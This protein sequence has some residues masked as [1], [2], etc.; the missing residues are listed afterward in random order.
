MWI[1]EYWAETAA[2]IL[3][4]CQ[5]TRAIWTAVAY[6]FNSPLL[7]P[8]S[9]MDISS[10]KAWWSERTSYASALGKPRAKATTSLILLT[11]WAV[12]K[13]RNRRIF[14]HKLLRPS[15]VCALIKEGA[16]LWIH[17]GISSSRTP[18]SEIFGRNCI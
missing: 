8:S 17:A 18:I 10:V 11:L 14:Q 9:W 16:T 6:L 7:H 13:E 12:W 1:C 4:N 15:G 2:H 5:F 3:L